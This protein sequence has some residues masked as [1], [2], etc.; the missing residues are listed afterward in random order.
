MIKAS[1]RYHIRKNIIIII[2][3]SIIPINSEIY[4]IYGEYL[5]ESLF[6][7]ILT[8]FAIGIFYLVFMMMVDIIKEKWCN[9]F[10]L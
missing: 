7:G 3:T 4:Y 6:F 5:I 10:K 2:L 9:F 1:L 8:S